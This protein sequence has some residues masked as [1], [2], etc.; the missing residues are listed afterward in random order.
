MSLEFGY[1]TAGLAA[2]R[3]YFVRKNEAQQRKDISA[4]LNAAMSSLDL[5]IVTIR[6]SRVAH[7]TASK[8]HLEDALLASS[9]HSMQ[10]SLD[11]ASVLL[12]ELVDLPPKEQLPG[13]TAPYDNRPLI[14]WGYWG[15]FFT[16]GLLDDARNS[17][18]QIYECATRY[19]GLAVNLFSASF[20][21][22]TTGT[23]MKEICDYHE[24]LTESRSLPA[25]STYSQLPAN[26]AKALLEMRIDEFVDACRNTLREIENF[27]HLNSC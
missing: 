5:Q 7:A 6:Q 24:L 14:A 27:K 2:V 26:Q 1:V 17:L 20:F 15:R 22:M 13:E 11:R 12:T 10:T 3:M 18:R 19:P 21:P 25:T 8:R 16:F 9:L 23:A 4:T